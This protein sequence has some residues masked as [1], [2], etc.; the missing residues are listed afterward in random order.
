VDNEPQKELTIREAMFLV[1]DKSPQEFEKMKVLFKKVSDCFDVGDDINGLQILSNE[2]FPM[3]R[4]LAEFCSSIFDYHLRVLGEDVGYEFCERLK[5]LNNLLATLAEETHKSNLTEVGD[6]L[7]FD[8]Y[9]FINELETFFPE[10]RKCFEES[11][12]PGLDQY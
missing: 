9:D 12:F 4:S 1:L 6:I 10:I 11:K 3:V 8:M 7:R 5:Q 2:V